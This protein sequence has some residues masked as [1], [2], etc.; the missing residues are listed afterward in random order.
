M[1]TR[2]L[3]AIALLAGVPLIGCSQPPGIRFQ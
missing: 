1:K 2:N 3:L